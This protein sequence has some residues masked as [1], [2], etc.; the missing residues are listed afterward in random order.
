MAGRQRIL[1]VIRDSSIVLLIQ[2]SSTGNPVLIEFM[3]VR[4]LHS[5]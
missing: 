5:D 4:P 2:D 3:D 1:L